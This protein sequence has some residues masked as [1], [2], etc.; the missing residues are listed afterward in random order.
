MN[1]FGSNAHVFKQLVTVTPE[2][3]NIG[4][5]IGIDK[6]YNAMEN[7]R[8]YD[9]VVDKAVEVVNN[10]ITQRPEDSAARV[11]FVFPFALSIVNITYLF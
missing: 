1:L 3:S 7:G 11:F 6:F 8:S 9:E 2:G 4:V 10:G 5:N